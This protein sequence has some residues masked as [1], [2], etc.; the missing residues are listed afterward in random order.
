MCRAQKSQRN[1]SKEQLGNVSGKQQTF[2]VSVSAP[3]SNDNPRNSRN[4]L[5]QSNSLTIN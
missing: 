4:D 5:P 2:L 3:S 1:H